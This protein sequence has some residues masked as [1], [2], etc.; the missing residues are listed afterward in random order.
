MP[1][2]LTGLLWGL[3]AGMTLL[4]TV[5][6]ASTG[7]ALDPL[8]NPWLFA[9]I[10]VLIT[11]T[12]YY[13]TI[14]PDVRLKTVSETGTQILLVL[15]F[16]ILLSYA[17]AAASRRFPYSDELLAQLDLALGFERRVYLDF[18]AGHSWLRR[19]TSVAY[20]TLLPQFLLVPA[21]LFTANQISRVHVW[22]IAVA[23]ALI[24]TSAI[25]I[26]T[27]SLT[28][29]VY[30][31]LKL[32]VPPGIYTPMPTIEALRAGTF[33]AIRLD[34][35]EALISFPSFHTAG[36][37]LFVWALWPLNVLRWGGLV[38]NA[39]LIAATPIDGAHYLVD[40]AGGAAVAGTALAVSLGLS[41]RVAV[42]EKTSASPACK[43]DSGARIVSER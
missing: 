22:L 41:R 36:A 32:L 24:V 4:T 18:F 19:L 2:T 14:R 42:A 11:V 8:S 38:L 27:P 15:L 20:L 7:L 9:L 10:A 17:A 5:G 33:G 6:F 12:W 26:C 30:S 3:I 31:D 34:N 43:P 29:F 16:G 1:R 40:V 25:S 39:A 23:F 13:S 35:L 28:A 21:I 37:I